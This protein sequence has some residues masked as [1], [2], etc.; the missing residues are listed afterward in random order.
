MPSGCRW[1]LSDKII[2]QNFTFLSTKEISIVPWTAHFKL[3]LKSLIHLMLHLTI[4]GDNVSIIIIL[5]VVFF[6]FSLFWSA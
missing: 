4:F 3:F 2:P 5:F 6:H 1:R